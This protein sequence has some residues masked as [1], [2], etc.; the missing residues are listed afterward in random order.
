MIVSHKHRFIFLKTE[1]T[2]GTS[3]HHALAP[4]CG[5]DDIIVGP[6]RHPK[7]NKPIGRKPD[8]GLI[9]RHIDVPK[10]FKRRFPALGGYYAHMPAAQVRALVGDDVWRGYFKFAVERNPWDRQVSNYF[11][12]ANR[13]EKR[14]LSP[15]SFDAYITSPI[16]RRVHHV[17]LDNWRI[18]TIDDAIAVDDV[19]RY[20]D[21]DNACRG[22]A[23]RLGLPKTIA[24]PRVRGEHRPDGHG[25][26]SYYSERTAAIV[27]RWYAKEIEAFG[28]AF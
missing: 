8:P 13:R 1:K 10:A 27:G 4:F 7:T 24:L 15:K 21:L 19:L 2:A 9:G 23:E 11:H 6:R 5:P 3:L 12:R 22:L 20:E 28:Y 14:G 16:L 17:R 26:R 18:Y 25:Y